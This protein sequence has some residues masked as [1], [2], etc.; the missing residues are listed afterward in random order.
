MLSG[1]FYI[2]NFGISPARVNRQ[3][4]LARQVFTQPETELKGYVADL[5]N[6]DYSGYR[7]LGLIEQYPG[8]RDNFESYNIYKLNATQE[9]ERP[10]VRLIRENYD[11]IEAFQ[12]D[13]HQLIAYRVL[14]LLAHVL[15]ASPDIFIDKHR[16]DDDC[17]SFLR[18]LKYHPRSSETN[19]KYDNIYTRAHTDFGS[20]TMLFSNEVG[21][22]EIQTSD[23]Q[24]Y[25]TDY[26]PE[27]V[28]VSFADIISVW[29][30]G[31]VRSCMHRVVSPPAE[32]EHLERF[33]LIY[34]LRPSNQTR[35]EPLHSNVLS[36]NGL[37]DQPQSEE[38]QEKLRLT[39]GE[40][41]KAHT[42]KK[43]RKADDKA[44]SQTAY[45]SF[46]GQKA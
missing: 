16:W 2:T 40:W 34:F 26:V 31:Y 29:S 18:Y 4:S 44:Q 25:A 41:V 12:R 43:V 36:K 21:G 14:Q 32:Q 7:P 22:L 27:G 11:E 35:L 37:A 46:F 1:L 9:R 42:T 13:T 38:L 33:S 23:G 20:I 39:V 3:W 28:V 45:K 15:Q 8:L 24:W 5:A 6:G 19:K 10:H 30:K 17:S